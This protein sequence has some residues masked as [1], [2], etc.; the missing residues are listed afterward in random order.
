MSTLG[1]ILCARAHSLRLLSENDCQNLLRDLVV[2]QVRP[3]LLSSDAANL[4]DGR[5]SLIGVG[6][7]GKEEFVVRESVHPSEG[8]VEGRTTLFSLAI[9]IIPL[10]RSLQKYG[11]EQTGRARPMTAGKRDRRGQ[12]RKP[13]KVKTT[14]T[15]SRSFPPGERRSYPDHF[16]IHRLRRSRQ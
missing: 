13:A 1:F 2:A 4:I 12:P 3:G 6:L 9:V 5:S 15:D 14:K 8:R 16:G 7:S 11:S 10:M